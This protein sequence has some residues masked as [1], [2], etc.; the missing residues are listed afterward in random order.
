MFTKGWHKMQISVQKTEASLYIDCT[1]IQTVQMTPSD[2]SNIG[3]M[4]VAK[5]MTSKH[6]TPKVRWFGAIVA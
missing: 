1:R 5:S 6:T 2:V 4:T 3:Y